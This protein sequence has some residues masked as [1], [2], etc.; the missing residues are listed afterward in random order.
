[1]TVPACVEM[2]FAIQ[3]AKSPPILI[4]AHVEEVYFFGWEVRRAKC[5]VQ[6]V[7]VV[8]REELEPLV[9]DRWKRNRMVPIRLQPPSTG[10]LELAPRRMYLL[11]RL[12]QLNLMLLFHVLPPSSLLQLSFSII[13]LILHHIIFFH[14]S[15]SA[16]IGPLRLH[17]VFNV[18]IAFL[19]IFIV[20]LTLIFFLLG[21]QL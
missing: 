10:F 1:M 3:S 2:H 19:F 9:H 11:F 12:L 6:P 7:G 8:C 13:A 4:F 15:V 18:A 20:T 21:L 17:V 16:I 14:I 5:R